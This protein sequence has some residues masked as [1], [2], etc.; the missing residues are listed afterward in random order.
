MIVLL[1]VVI[2]YPFFVPKSEHADPLD[3]A[4]V[5][6]FDQEAAKEDGRYPH[7]SSGKYEYRQYTRDSLPA[8]N[9][10]PRERH[11]FV[12]DLNAADS[13]DL[14]E[15]YGIG[16]YFAHSIVKYRTLLGGYSSMEQLK[17]VNGMSSELYAAITPHLTL[18]SPQVRT[19]NINTATISELKHHPYLDY[20][21]AKAIVALRDRGIRFESPDDLLKVSLLDQETIDK[22]T[23][24]LAFDND[25][26]HSHPAGK[27]T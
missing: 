10:Q 1:A 8:P 9:F 18:N 12:V 14:Q 21:Q 4:D 26:I 22:L 3:S 6:Q 15:I 17:E 23:P 25:T 19:I 16:P 5:A 2:F 24:Y 20:W 7:R 13:L 11:E 27:N